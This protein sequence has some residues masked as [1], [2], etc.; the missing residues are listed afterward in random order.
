MNKLFRLTGGRKTLL[1]LILILGSIFAMAQGHIDF[2]AWQNF[3]IY[4][5]G[6][7]VVGNGIEHI[8]NGIKKY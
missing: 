5:F 4:I 1:A 2:E 6:A 8:G 3:V 7:Y